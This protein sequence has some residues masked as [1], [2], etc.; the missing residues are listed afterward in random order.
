MVLSLILKYA[1]KK[2]LISNSIV[3]DIEF[4]TQREESDNIYLNEKEIQYL[5][6]LKEFKNKGEEIVRDMFVLGCYTGLR[7]RNY[8]SINLDYLS[9]DILTIIQQKLGKK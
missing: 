2:K 9:D 5:M 1:A 3:H 6:D 8:S 7:F 4:S